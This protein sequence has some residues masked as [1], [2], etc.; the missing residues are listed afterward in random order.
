MKNVSDP[1]PSA[2]A[3]DPALAQLCD[4]II[5]RLQAGD[6]VDLASMAV[7]YPEHAEQLRRIFPV[8]EAL[9]DL[10]ASSIHNHSSTGSSPSHGASGPTPRILGDYRILREVG[11]GGM[12]VVYEAEQRSLNRRVALKVLPMAAA[13]DA[14][15]FQRFQLEAQAAACLHH[16]N[17][18]PVFAVGAEGGVP[19]YAMQY[20][21]GRSLADV[22]HELRRAE[23]LE[24]E[25]PAPDGGAGPRLAGLSTT[26][27]ARSLVSG[28][29]ASASAQADAPDADSPTEGWSSRG[30]PEAATRSTPREN[31]NS[32]PATRAA[33]NSGSSTRS[34]DY[35][36]N[37]AILGLQAAEALD[38]AHTRGIL[39]RDIKP[40]NL[41]LDGEGR[42]WVTDFG[43]AQIQGSSG[44]TLSGDILGTLR[45][46]SPE[47]ALAK[48]IVIDGRTDIYSLGVTLYELLTLQP[49]FDGKDRAEI[50]RR[51]ASDEPV[52][53]RKLNPSIPIDLE[54]IIRKA[55]AKEPTE[56]YPT[57]KDLADDLRRFL[58]N[59]PIAAVRPSPWVH[60][61][62]WMQRHREVTI[63]LLLVVSA[64]AVLAGAWAVDVS[65]RRIQLSMDVG[66]MLGA[67]RSSLRTND[68][69]SALRHLAEA[70]GHLMQARDRTGSLVR[71]LDLLSGE[72]A[73]RVR[74]EQ[75]YHQFQDLRRRVDL[76]ASYEPRALELCHNALQLYNVTDTTPWEPPRSFL[77]LPPTLQAAARN[78]I[79]EL[80][81]LLSRLHVETTST[82]AARARGHR[83]AIDDLH[84]L[85]AMVGTLPAASLWLAQSWD[86][87]G[88]N[89]RAR[90]A[91]RSAEDL[92]VETA[93]N[94]FMIGQYKY[95]DGKYEDALDAYRRALRHQPNHLSSLLWAG[96]TLF[97]L[98]RFE[99]AEA[100]F[101][102]AIALSPDAPSAY[103]CRGNTYQSQGKF[104]LA[105]E[106][107]AKWIEL[108]PDNHLG[109]SSLGLLLSR[110]GNHADALAMY[111]RALDINPHSY[112]SLLNRGVT[113][114]N[115]GQDEK[116]C[117]DYTAV[118]NMLTPAM[119]Y[120]PRDPTDVDHL[121]T[122]LMNRAINLAE[123]GR[124]DQAR[125]DLEKVL[126]INPELTQAYHCRA[127][128][129]HL[130]AGQVKE[131]VED[132]SRVVELSPKEPAGYLNRGMV[133]ARHEQYQAGIADA[134]YAL[135]LRAETL[136]KIDY[137]NAACVY[138]LASA[139]AA[140]DGHV[141][142]GNALA[143]RY[144]N[145][146]IELLRDAVAHGW[147]GRHDLDHLCG[148]TDLDPIRDHPDFRELLKSVVPVGDE[149]GQGQ[150]VKDRPDSHHED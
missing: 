116:A 139:R 110:R 64:M 52:P 3:S 130:P 126:E 133:L 101:T 135:G 55:L 79:H 85:E 28:H 136:T 58:D 26:A 119:E 45:Y 10:G 15:Q 41:L 80:L 49:A 111:D 13:L 145:R 50:L 121:V 97:Q 2:A 120:I 113:Y 8:L 148:D 4:E 102:G 99:A 25:P 107:F 77:D 143:L 76:L 31:T 90:Q 146:A 69:A 54:T 82:A 12:G 51:I 147:K 75:R 81:F 72:V 138:S 17:I 87:L 47:Q 20:I 125:E 48:R 104:D 53:P 9:V 38:H 34:R 35:C 11:R 134:D 32:R 70:R 96:Q 6:R 66:R 65:R 24:P 105:Q 122:A 91:S 57:S 63:V 128:M 86:A 33:V 103:R 93:L 62:K 109:Y 115:L 14:R 23:G 21:E 67:A 144:A 95:R 30:T 149:K 43:L 1:F 36:R 112:N 39:H 127:K 59:K 18:V 92:T 141:P 117:S 40:G 27:L 78:S 60:A 94:E 56:R 142:D 140:D 100:M 61:W 5:E 73:A 124:R 42:L 88:E 83:R 22:L 16:N 46:M 19:F 98:K 108:D 74:A 7:Q 89:E 106:D 150:V 29:A 68:T 37:I 44:P 132:L 118:I 71:E 131:A 123:R 114:S 84:R 137:Y 129:V